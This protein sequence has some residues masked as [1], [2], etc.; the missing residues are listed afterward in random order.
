MVRAFGI[1]SARPRN[2]VSCPTASRRKV[3]IEI[4][5]EDLPIL[6]T[7]REHSEDKC[8]A[9][10][11]RFGIRLMGIMAEDVKQARAKSNGGDRE[12]SVYQ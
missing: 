11:F 10:A 4:Y 7:F 2:T 12:W 9:E 1:A 8:D 3:K 5:A 6:E